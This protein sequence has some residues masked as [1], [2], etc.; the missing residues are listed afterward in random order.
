MGKTSL[1]TDL[2]FNGITVDIFV[3]V[4][5]EEESVSIVIS[6][7]LLA[8]SCHSVV[9]LVDTKNI[10]HVVPGSHYLIHVIISQLLVQNL[11]G[12]ELVGSVVVVGGSSNV[13]LIIGSRTEIPCPVGIWVV[14]IWEHI[15][16]F[17]W[18]LST[19]SLL[20]GV[21]CVDIHARGRVEQVVCVTVVLIHPLDHGVHIFVVLHSIHVSEIISEKNEALIGDV[22]ITSFIKIVF[23]IFTSLLGVEGIRCF[24]VDPRLIIIKNI[25]VKILRRRVMG[26]EDMSKKVDVFTE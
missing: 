9:M 5:T 11:L 7:G 26:V 18:E 12:I 20:S 8:S 14:S 16:I 24:V 10:K 23:E 17:G 2:S 1:S 15:I 13:L 4:H 21:K 25:K 19:L 3:D 6:N 22:M